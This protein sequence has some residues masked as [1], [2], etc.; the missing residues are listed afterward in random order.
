MLE[1]TDAKVALQVVDPEAEEV[2]GVEEDDLVMAPVLNRSPRRA[3]LFPFPQR[4]RR[5]PK[6]LNGFKICL[7]Q[8]KR[9]I[10]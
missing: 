7:S 3:L 10:R 1:V 5:L 4:L 9:N 6:V 8:T 2:E